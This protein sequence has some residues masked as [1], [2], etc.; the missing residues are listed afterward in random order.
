MKLTWNFQREEERG[1][2]R[3]EGGRGR[4][5]KLDNVPWEGYGNYLEQ[6]SHCEFSTPFSL[7]ILKASTDSIL[8]K[9][10]VV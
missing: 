6:P 4:K 5:P 3:G 7:Q 9:K 8:P 1:G 2:G 10:L